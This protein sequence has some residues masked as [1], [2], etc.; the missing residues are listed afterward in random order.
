MDSLTRRVW[1][2]VQVG[3]TKEYEISIPESLKAQ[4]KQYGL[5]HHITSTVYTCQGDAL[6]RL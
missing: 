4:K 5:K 3:T 2:E 6:H 1:K